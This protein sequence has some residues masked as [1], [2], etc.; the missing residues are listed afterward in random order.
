MEPGSA[1]WSRRPEMLTSWAKRVGI[2]S[3]GEGDDVLL[4]PDLPLADRLPGQI[5]VFLARTPRPARSGTR[6][7]EGSGATRSA[8]RRSR[9]VRRRAAA[10]PIRACPRGRGRPSSRAGPPVATCTSNPD[11]FGSSKVRDIRLDQGPVHRQPHAFDPRQLHQRVV[12]ALGSPL[13][14]DPDEP[15]RHDRCDAAAAGASASS[16]TVRRMSRVLRI[17]LTE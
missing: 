17:C 1:R 14:R 7:R 5:R 16:A 3:G 11:Q 13:R 15:P 9:P 8:A 4:V 6:L 2:G 12:G 10:R